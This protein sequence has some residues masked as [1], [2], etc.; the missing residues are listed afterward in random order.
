MPVI[1]VATACLPVNLKKE[2]KKGRKG[3]REGGRK[4]GRKEE[5]KE[6]KEKI[7]EKIIVENFPNMGKDIVQSKKGRES[8]TG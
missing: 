4:E 3:G 8:H 2:R 6:E 7:F 1:H 5:R